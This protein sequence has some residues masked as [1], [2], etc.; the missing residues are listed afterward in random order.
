[1]LLRRTKLYQ[2]KFADVRSYELS[3]LKKNEPL[4]IQVGSET[5]TLTYEEAQKKRLSLTKEAIQSKVNPEQTY[6]LFSY[7]FVPDKKPTEEEIYNKFL[8]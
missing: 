5:M 3:E 2:G 7:L 1:M 8:I 4:I 6:Y